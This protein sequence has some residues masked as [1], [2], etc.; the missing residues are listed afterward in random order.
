MTA[1]AEDEGALLGHS[2]FGA[3][4]DPDV[5][6]EVGEVRSFF[7]APT[8]WRRGVGTALMRYALADLHERGYTVATVWS[9]A[10]NERANAFYAAHGFS[11]DGTEREEEIWADQLEVRLRRSLP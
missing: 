5:G 3:T 1:V 8:S 7:V 6:P 9:F 10:A 2:S 11:P 4:R